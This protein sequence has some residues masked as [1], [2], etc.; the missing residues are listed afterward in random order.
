MIKLCVV[1][2]L[3]GATLS[4]QPMDCVGHGIKADVGVFEETTQGH[5]LT[6]IFIC[7]RKE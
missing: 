1:V 3:S 4:P 2:L 6:G 5:S 7:V